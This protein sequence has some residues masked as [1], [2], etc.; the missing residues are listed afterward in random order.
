MAQKDSGRLGKG[1]TS[2]VLAIRKREEK[3][4]ERKEWA[5]YQG[6]SL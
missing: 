2:E 5:R 4:T 3:T 1:K 6:I